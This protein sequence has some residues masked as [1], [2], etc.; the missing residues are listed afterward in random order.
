MKN[1]IILIFENESDR[2][3]IFACSICNVQIGLQAWTAR[4][5]PDHG[6]FSLDSNM[7]R[8][9]KTTATLQFK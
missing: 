8:T 6:P 3:H 2:V 9:T 5:L 4:N 7:Q 1:K